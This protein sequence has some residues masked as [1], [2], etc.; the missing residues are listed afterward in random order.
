MAKMY[1]N[2][3]PMESNSSGERKVFEYFKQHA[4]EEWIV[5]HSFRLPNHHTVVF[6]EADFIVIAPGYGVFVLEIKSGGVGFDGSE[7]CF[8]NRNHEKTYKTRGPFQQ[9]REA[10]FE[11]KKILAERTGFEF[12]VKNV[13][14]G[15]GVIFTD[16]ADFPTDAL[17]EDEKWRLCQ[18]TEEVD[19]CAFIKK[20]SHNFLIELNRLGKPLPNGLSD[21]SADKIAKTLRPSVDCVVPLRSFLHAS[22]EEIIALTEEQYACLDDIEINDR[23]VVTGGAGTGKTLLAVEEAKRVADV[24]KV[25]VFC[26]NKNLAHFIKTNLQ[27]EDITVYSVHSYM[28]KLCGSLLAGITKNDQ[29]WS[30]LPELAGLKA[31]EQS[32]QFDRIIVDEFQD[33]CTREYLTFFDIVLKNGLK[34]GKFTFYGDFARQAIYQKDSSLSELDGFTYY[35]KKHLSINC[36]NTIFIGNELV[37]ITGYSDKKYKLQ[38]TGEPVDYLVWENEDEERTK[39]FSCLKDLKNNG[40]DASSIII[41][42]PKK[43]ENSIVNIVDPDTFI[44]GNYGDDPKVYYALFSTVHSFKGLESE[45]VI[46]SDIEDYSES[47]LMYVALSRARSKLI[48]LES[49]EASEQRKK[50]IVSR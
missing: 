5:L 42:S 38:I 35:A 46:L 11:I 48:I 22:E 6:G 43:R 9:A 37:N 28:T 17:V 2:T 26:F 41:L 3:F 23:M 50:L 18:R 25:A 29:Y 13:L 14:Y 39:L 27:N 34:A 49:L 15:Y 12:S 10:M 24:E 32:I 8:I 21:E 45:V 7:W 33:L 31:K 19:Y 20:L 1:P 40:F 44:V 30:Q 16:E 47:R 36:R 4:P